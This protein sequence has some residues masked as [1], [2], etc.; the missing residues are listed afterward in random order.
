[1]TDLPLFDI[2]SKIVGHGGG[3]TLGEAIR[4]NQ[5]FDMY[6]P[7]PAVEGYW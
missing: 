4:F 1:M 3:V 2:M 7:D 5:D 6:S